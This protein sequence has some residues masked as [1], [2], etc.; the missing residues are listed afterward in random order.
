MVT[1]LASL[2]AVET[3]VINPRQV[4]KI[5]PQRSLS[6]ECVCSQPCLGLAFCFSTVRSTRRVCMESAA[7]LPLGAGG[8]AE[9]LPRSLGDTTMSY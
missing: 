5:R 3:L 8:R 7:S 4:W 9:S 1:P 2:S 6:R